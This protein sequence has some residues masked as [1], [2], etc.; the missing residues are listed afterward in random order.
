MK[1]DWYK[2]EIEEVQGKLSKEPYGTDDYKAYLAQLRELLDLQEKAKAQKVKI[3]WKS[4]GTL[5]VG[6]G[7]LLVAIRGQNMSRDVAKLAYTSEE[8][9]KLCNNRVWNEKNNIMKIK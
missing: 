9:M 2:K 7:S 8:E 5:I 6:A 3:D 4:I 1:K